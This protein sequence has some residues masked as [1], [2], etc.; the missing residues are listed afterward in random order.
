LRTLKVGFWTDLIGAIAMKL[1]IYPQTIWQ[2]LSHQLQLFIHRK[3]LSKLLPL[4]DCKWNPHL[5]GQRYQLHFAPLRTKKLKILEIGI[6]GVEVGVSG[7]YADDPYS[8][9][10]SLRMWKNYFPNS[11]IYGIDIIDKTALESDRIKIFQGSQ[12]DEVFLKKVVEQT[13]KLDIIIDDGSHHNDHV[14]KTFK[15]LF[16]E[17]NDG[18]IYIIEDTHTS[19]IPSYENWSKFSDDNQPPEWSQ[20]GGSLDLYDPKTMMNF[21][22]RLVDCLSHQEFF[23]PGYLPN[24]FDKHILGIHFYR[25]QIFIYKGNNTEPGNVMENNT[26]R[27]E[28]LEEI[29]I[30]AIDKLGL[31]FP[32]IDDPTK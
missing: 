31:S 32:I 11:M 17:L 19:Y 22:K 23:N 6:G 18:G 7:G 14:I 4:Y 15:V 30:D 21:F 13:G 29:G 25:N 9:G 28:F 2:N 10:E 5:F 26:L 27:P 8:G 20:Y 3:D 1:D 24:Y 16:P 12:D